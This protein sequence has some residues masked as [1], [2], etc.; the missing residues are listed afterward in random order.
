MFGLLDIVAITLNKNTEKIH[1]NSKSSYIEQPGS[2]TW[3][4]FLPWKTSIETAKKYNLLP[5]E[6]DL[7]VYEV[8]DDLLGETP[9]LTL[10]SLNQI[11]ADFV[12]LFEQYNLVGKEIAFLGLS[13]GTI[14][15]FYLANRYHCKKLVAACPTSKLGEG[16]FSTYAA[17]DIKKKAIKN[18]FTAQ[19]YDEFIK[20]INIGN[21]LSN[22]PDDITLYLGR[23][24]R[25]VPFSGGSLLATKIKECKN[26]VKVKKFN[27]FGH[28]LALYFMGKYNKC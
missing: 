8:A 24:D 14:P 6:G 7:I 26:N 20:D 13:A 23:F 22:L 15:A 11:C 21:N 9:N 2:L 28:I 25:F 3:I 1:N 16:I 19:S 12:T 4:C 10:N 17:R 18:G 27:F 5:N